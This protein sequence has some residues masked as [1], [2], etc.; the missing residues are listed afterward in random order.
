MYKSQVYIY[1]IPKYQFKAT[2]INYSPKFD[3]MQYIW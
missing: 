1:T 3:N 2:V